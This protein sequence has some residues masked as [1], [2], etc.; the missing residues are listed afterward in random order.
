ME[1]AVEFA[2]S[3]VLIGV[4][5]TALMDGWA[6]VEKWVFG[7]PF[8]DYSMVGRWLGHLRHGRLSHDSI[9]KAAPIKHEGMIGWAA[10]YAI[11]IAFAVLLLGVFG[12]DWARDPSFVPALVVGLATVAAPFYILQPA[13]GAGIAASRTPRPSIARLKS[14]EAH[15]S[16]GI[17]LYL[18]AKALS[19]VAAF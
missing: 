17:G 9:A 1:S 13:L 12:L 14:I 7:T 4:G 18:A 10:H 2:I 19:L 8:R 5:A 11:G 16:F 15:L 3:A 6:L